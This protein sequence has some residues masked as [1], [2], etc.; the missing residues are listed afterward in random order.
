SPRIG[1]HL[2]S[3]LTFSIIV[4]VLL[5]SILALMNVWEIDIE[6]VLISGGAAAIIIGFVI[7]TIAGNIFSGGLMLTTFPARVGD[8]IFIVN[9]NIRGTVGEVSFLY[10][11]VI[12]D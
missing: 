3:V 7:S 9:D 8:S 11:K 6:A 12:S 1:L 10:T 2:S 5:L 4:T